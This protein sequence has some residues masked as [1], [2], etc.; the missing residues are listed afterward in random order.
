MQYLR[1][2]LDILINNHNT[3]ISKEIKKHLVEI[4]ALNIKIKQL[5]SSLSDKEKRLE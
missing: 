5:I 1:S 4:T 2:Q 3:D